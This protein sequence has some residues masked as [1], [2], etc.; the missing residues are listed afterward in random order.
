MEKWTIKVEQQFEIKAG[1]YE[2]AC[3]LLPEYGWSPNPSWVMVKETI[4]G[5]HNV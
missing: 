2:E 3:Q 4:E 5:G 1:S